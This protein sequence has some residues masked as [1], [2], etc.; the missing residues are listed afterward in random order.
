MPSLD[1]LLQALY[2]AWR[3]A[4]RAAYIH[5]AEKPLRKS[6][7]GLSGSVEEF[8]RVRPLRADGAMEEAEVFK[9]PWHEVFPPRLVQ[10]TQLEISF[11]CRIRHKASTGWYMQIVRPVRWKWL[12]K[13]RGVHHVDILLNHPD[14]P[15]GEIR[16][17]GQLWQRFGTGQDKGAWW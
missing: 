9:V 15:R 7:A 10:P 8:L 2:A 4:C 12:A 14:A 13:R 11:D 1:S 5:Y 17:N 16:I 6:P 3:N